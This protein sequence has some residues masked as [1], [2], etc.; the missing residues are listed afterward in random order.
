M[1]N[2]RI[3][4]QLLDVSPEVFDKDMCSSLHHLVTLN[5]LLFSEQY[6][7]RRGMSAE[8]TALKLTNGVLLRSNKNKLYAFIWL[9]PR[10]LKFIH[11]RF[12]TLCSISQA[13]R[14]EEWTGSANTS[15]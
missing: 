2:R 9:Y 14:C 7:F 12:G 15:L 1:T 10:R 11:R 6:G 8:N 13:G 5:S 4:S 3:L